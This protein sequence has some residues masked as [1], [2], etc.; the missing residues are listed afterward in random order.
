MLPLARDALLSNKGFEPLPGE[1]V[2]DFFRILSRGEWPNLNAKKI[3]IGLRV[4][5]RYQKN[6]IAARFQDLH[7]RFGIL[8]GAGRRHLYGNTFADFTTAGGGGCGGC[9]NRLCR[10]GGSGG[11]ARR[12]RRGFP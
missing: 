12:G 4:F 6:R 2:A 11:G 9:L 10:L 7:Q 5:R 1:L 3:V 8:L